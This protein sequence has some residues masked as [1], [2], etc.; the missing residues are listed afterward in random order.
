V[1][2]LAVQV[3]ITSLA[4]VPERLTACGLPLALS[5]ML[6]EAARL[7]AAEGVNSTAIVQLAPALTE[8]PQVLVW[9]KSPALVPVKARLVIL[10]LVL[11]VLVRVTACDELV[12][13]TGWLPKARL[14]TERLTVG[15]LLAPV[16]VRR[17]VWGLLVALSAMET[18]AVWLPLAK[19]VKVTLMVQFAPAATELAHVLVCAKPVAFVPVTARP[20]M[21][22]AALPVFVS[23]MVCALLVVPTAWLAKVKLIA[24][25]LTAGAE[26]A[27][28]P[29]PFRSTVQVERLGVLVIEIVPQKLPAAV[30]AK[31]T[32][33]VKV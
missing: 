31:V 30:G 22:R 8:L 21:V 2:L 23:L 33:K 13:S 7:P 17:T 10:T 25:K 11:P 6:S 4:P 19:G 12:T 1:V 14:L 20:E 24:D 3:R 29:V 15:V 5:V 27:A 9:E 18:E 16:P 32:L 26:A 28:T